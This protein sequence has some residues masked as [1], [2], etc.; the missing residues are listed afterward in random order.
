MHRKLPHFLT[1]LLLFTLSAFARN[2]QTIEGNLEI[3]NDMF[4][5]VADRD[6][7]GRSDFDDNTVTSRRIMLIGYASEK[8]KDLVKL[9]GKRVRAKGILGQ[10]FTRYHTEP[11]VLSLE[12]FPEEIK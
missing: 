2:T 10:A 5:I 12:G 9:A 8:V 7:S 11:L 6:F 4:V 1:L 3:A